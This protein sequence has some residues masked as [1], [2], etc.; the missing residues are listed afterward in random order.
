MRQVL[1]QVRGGTGEEAAARASEFG[2]AT[3]SW[4]SGRGGDGAE[5][6]LLSVAIENVELDP[7]LRALEDFGPIEASVPATGAFAFEPPK[8]EPSKQLVDVT[9]R[10][11]IEI[12][13]AG[14][15]SVGSWTG[16]V[17]YA[18]VAGVV[19]WI[20]L[21]TGTAYLLTAAMLLAPFAGPAMNTAIAVSSGDVALLRRGVLRYLA[22]VA[23]TAAVCTLLT[24]V[25]GQHRIS[26]LTAEVLTVSN[27]A[28]LLPI[29]A[30]IA[31]ANHLVQ[32]EHSSLVSGAAVG[33]LVAA[34]LAPPAGGLGIAVALGRWDLVGPAT[35][36]VAL[37]LAGITLTAAAVFRLYGLTP[38]RGRFEH[39]RRGLLPVALTGL[40]LV[41][42]A[43][44]AV[45]FLTTTA[46]QTTS[47]AQTATEVATDVVEDDDRVVLL[48]VSS[49]T[50]TEVR[51][52]PLRLLLSVHVER[53]TE[54]GDPAA[55]ERDLEERIT[56]AV[57][58]EVQGIAV[59]V[60]VTSYPAPPGVS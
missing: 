18:A 9:P 17:T 10:S 6:D 24:L 23:I 54:V 27:V 3:L 34:S 43:L 52:G 30:G 7:L 53:V 19:V 49:S 14:Q 8:G 2:A 37:Q 58:G 46:L 28:V 1:L 4:W 33:M 59:A 35:F 41:I 29:A 40:S 16:F 60:D 36:Q 57:A 48:E 12:F 5:V 47:L 25:L 32:S 45:Q 22:G 56:G 11:P 42:G 21:V 31:G 13:L 44:L 50:P 38:G 15:Q 26:D 55:F 20:G 51:P 39:G